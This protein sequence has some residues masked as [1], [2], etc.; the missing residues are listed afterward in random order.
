MDHCT[1]WGRVIFLV[2]ILLIFEFIFQLLNRFYHMVAFIIGMNTREVLPA[3]HL[4][5][6]QSVMGK[7]RIISVNVPFIRYIFESIIR[8]LSSNR[9]YYF[10]CP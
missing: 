9:F 2:F 3:S 6:H 8:A 4:A 10:L 7:R 5:E 1:K